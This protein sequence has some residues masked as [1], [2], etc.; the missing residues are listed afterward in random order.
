MVVRIGCV[1]RYIQVC[2]SS[3]V[4]RDL[5]R[6][7]GLEC[8]RYDFALRITTIFT[9]IEGVLGVLI[10][11]LYEQRVLFYIRKL[12]R[13]LTCRNTCILP[14]HT[15]LVIIPRESSRVSSNITQRQTIRHATC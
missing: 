11:T 15:V 10:K 1:H 13:F 14:R 5:V 7:D 6:V 9:Q 4:H 8:N 2:R 3:F 12:G